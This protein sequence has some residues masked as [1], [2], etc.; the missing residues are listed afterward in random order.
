MAKIFNFC[1]DGLLFP[2]LLSIG[3]LVAVALMNSPLV[4][5]LWMEG[6]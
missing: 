3:F 6:F 2:V 1:K 4:Q 5:A